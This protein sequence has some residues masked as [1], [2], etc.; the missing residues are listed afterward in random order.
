CR[1]HSRAR[2]PVA[3]WVCVEWHYSTTSHEMEFWL[4]GAELGDLHVRERA[5]APGSGCQSTR[6]LGGKWLAPPR[7]QSLYLGW[8]RYADTVNDQNVWFDDVVVSTARVGCPE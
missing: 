2:L 3:E 1:Q 5:T 8:E 6:D 7:W 4:D